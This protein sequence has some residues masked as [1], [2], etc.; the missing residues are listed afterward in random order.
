MKKIVALA[1]LLAAGVAAARAQESRQD[2]SLSGTALIEPFKASSTTV[3]VNSTPAYGALLSY[4]FMLTPTSALEA[5][6]GITYQNSIG[7]YVNPNHYKVLVRTQEL[8]GAFVKSFVFRNWNPFVEA[9]PGALIFLPILNS[10]TTTHDTKQQTE[11][12]GLYGAGI[13]YEISPSFDIRAEYRGLVVKV[14]TFGDSQFTTNRWYNIS[15]PVV[16]VAYHF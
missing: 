3:Q 14:P 10:G 4:R 8:S 15:E 6:Y 12:G 13:A 7:Y 2:I 1:I 16:G 9:G 5:N 11:V